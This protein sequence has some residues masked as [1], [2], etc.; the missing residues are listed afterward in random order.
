MHPFLGFSFVVPV[1]AV[2]NFEA[3]KL[4]E[5]RSASLGFLCETV[6]DMKRFMVDHV[7]GSLPSDREP[8][9]KIRVQ[10]SL[11]PRSDLVLLALKLW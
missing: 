4:N 10:F 11:I 6:K 5:P 7:M 9:S 2:L 1:G 8:T 3:V